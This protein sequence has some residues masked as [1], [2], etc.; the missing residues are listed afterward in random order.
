MTAP[1]NVDDD[2]LI[3]SMA[4]IKEEINNRQLFIQYHLKEVKK[5]LR[6]SVQL[7][8]C[9]KD[10]EQIRRKNIRTSYI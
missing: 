10:M 1:K 9:L 8:G 6:E 4:G 3:A 2:V 7:K 5:L